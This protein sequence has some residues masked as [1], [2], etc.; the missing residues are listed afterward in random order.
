MRGSPSGSRQDDPKQTPPVPAD[1]VGLR[2]DEKLALTPEEV[3]KAIGC[4]RAKV[5]D[6]FARHELPSVK[7]GKTRRVTVEALRRWLRQQSA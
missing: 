1:G 7:I 6:L 2:H 5:Y 3:G 4:S